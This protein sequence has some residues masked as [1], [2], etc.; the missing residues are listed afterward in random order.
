MTPH[1]EDDDFA[2]PA[3]RAS[4]E[5]NMVDRLQEQA[6]EAAKQKGWDEPLAEA[7]TFGDIV[8]LLHTEISEAYEDYREGRKLDEVYYEMLGE[9]ISPDN[10]EWVRQQYPNEILKPCGIPIEMADEVIR[11]LHFAS[12]AGFNL[13]NMIETKMHYNQSRAFRHGGKKT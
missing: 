7:K 13:Y 3:S 12:A 8:A 1:H 2:R 6:F 4:R 11:I 10:L 5:K 9:K